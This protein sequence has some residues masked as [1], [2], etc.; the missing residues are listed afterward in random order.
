[1]LNLNIKY[2]L[3]PKHS[4]AA[5]TLLCAA[6]I[7]LILFSVFIPNV[8]EDYT[9]SLYIACHIGLTI[10]MLLA[11][12]LN[13]RNPSSNKQLWIMYGAVAAQIILL[14]AS[15][16]TTHDTQRY[17]W[18]GAVFLN[19]LD[20]Y[21][22]TPNDPEAA[23]LRTIW[24][25][26][27]EHAKYPTIYPPAAI[28]IFA[29]AAMFGSTLGPLIWKILIALT[30]IA[31]IVSG[32]KLLI[33]YGKS[34]NLPLFALSPLLMLE[35][36]IGGHLDVFCVLLVTLSLI[37]WKQERYGLTGLF[38]GLCFTIKFLP[39]VILF[40]L[41]INAGFPRLNHKTLS[42]CSSFAASVIAVYGG[43]I[44]L[45]YEVIGVLP[46]FIEKWRFGSP[47]FSLA[48]NLVSGQALIITIAAIALLMLMLVYK[49]SRTSPILGCQI[50]YA[51][52]LLISPVVFPWYLCAFVP[53][54]AIRPT[55]T[56]LLWSSA[57]P[58]TYEVINQYNAS[59]IWE[60]ATWPI[61]VIATAILIGIGLDTTPSNTPIKH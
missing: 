39:A 24:P 22:T 11:W 60:I 17:L 53:L 44:L 47:L 48:S 20:P 42:L 18:D 27:A 2:H 51:I 7:M 34:E 16:F 15:P 33:L 14:M 45:G 10:I 43:F 52:P 55:A 35:T 5:T 40:P 46:T 50:M 49:V 30:T 31:T 56:I 28:G 3:G 12:W 21:I 26:P 61:G 59:G 4:N 9:G 8:T 1:M 13:S 41:A 19:G 32:R 58:L 29:F 6:F 37:C 23:Y 57:L 38:L 36:G 25:T 54:F